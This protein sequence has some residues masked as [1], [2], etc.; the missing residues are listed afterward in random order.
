MVILGI[1]PGSNAT[2][3]GLLR[4]DGR[5]WQHAASGVIRPPGRAP[6]AER[7]AAIDRQLRDLLAQAQPDEVAIESLFHAKSARSAIVLGHARGI[8]LVAARSSGA[9]VA[10][11]APREVKMAVTGAGGADKVRVR[12]MVGRLI[13]GVPSALSLDAADALAVAICHA[14]RRSDR[15]RE[16]DSIGARSGAPRTWAAVIAARKA[17]SGG[18]R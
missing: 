13:A 12:A 14:H 8:V 2:G 5:S 4:A 6:L 7:L 9:L 16:Q 11:Y 10:E 15:V 3:Y 18:G 1:D 17:G